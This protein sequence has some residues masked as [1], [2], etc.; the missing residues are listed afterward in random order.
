MTEAITTT[1]PGSPRE[2]ALVMA[3]Q[4]KI[5]GLQTEVAGITVTGSHDLEILGEKLAF[6]K[7]VEKALEDK[8]KEYTQPINK[9]LREVNAVFKSLSEPL[10]EVVRLA[11]SK[12]TSY[13]TRIRKEAEARIEAKRQAAEAERQAEI[14]AALE[15]N[16]PIPEPPPPLS[17]VTLPELEERIVTSWGKQTFRKMPRW[18]L[19]E[20]STTLEQLLESYRELLEI[21][22]PPG[23]RSIYEVARNRLASFPPDDYW[24]LDEI[25][26]GKIVRAG[27]RN[28]PGIDIWEEEIPA[29][30]TY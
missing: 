27:K 19:A 15:A 8:R 13:R 2:D 29:T 10:D 16:R 7:K 28:I 4:A 11:N 23:K 5:E 20:N 24:K 17:E 18:K 6:A 3:L 12:I 9:H 25:L 26:I 1:L 14:Q 30:T 21:E 22:P